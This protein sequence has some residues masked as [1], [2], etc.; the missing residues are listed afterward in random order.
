MA[1]LLASLGEPPYLCET[2]REETEA[3]PWPWVKFEALGFESKSETRG[4]PG[5]TGAQKATRL[6]NL[7]GKLV[8]LIIS[9]VYVENN[10]KW[11]FT[12]LLEHFEKNCTNT[13]KTKGTKTEQLLIPRKAKS[14]TRKK[15]GEFCIAKII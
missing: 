5:Q 3:T 15:C 13:L 4:Q 8:I 1:S 7:G 2:P 6:R 12:E 9:Y 11:Y 10:I 14:Y